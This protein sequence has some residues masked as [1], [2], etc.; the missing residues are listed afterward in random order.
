[1][2]AVIANRSRM[3]ADTNDSPILGSLSRLRQNMARQFFAPLTRWW[4][5]AD[6][7]SLA[8]LLQLALVSALAWVV[9]TVFLDFNRFNTLRTN[10]ELSIY[11][12]VGAAALAGVFSARGYF[13]PEENVIA[14][15]PAWLQLRRR[16]ADWALR[17]FLLTAAVTGAFWWLT[18]QVVSIATQHV[19]GSTVTYH[20]NVVLADRSTGPKARCQVAIAVRIHHA[21][22]KL[23]FCLGIKGGKPLGPMELGP[24]DAVMVR[25]RVNALGEAVDS[26]DYDDGGRK[27]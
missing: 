3:R 5:S 26:V 24:P 16:T 20:G 17:G 22:N 4:H 6:E 12:K 2:P 11:L 13:G 14:R 19:S 15:Y 23:E 21:P 1:V 18:S 25:T 9:V 7:R 8:I 10:T 27:T